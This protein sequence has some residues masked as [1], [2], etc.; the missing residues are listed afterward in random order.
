M[1]ILFLGALLGAFAFPVRSP[2]FYGETFGRAE[3]ADSILY[4]DRWETSSEE[5]DPEEARLFPAEPLQDET[6]RLPET[7]ARNRATFSVARHAGGGRRTLL[8]QEARQNGW[9]HRIEVRDD[10]LTRKRLGANAENAKGGGWRWTLGDLDDPNLPVWPAL[11]PRRTLPRGW[12][13][14]A[15]RGEAAAGLSSPVPQGIAAGAYGPR[16]KAWA[17]RGW[18]PVITGGEP[19]WSDAWNL[20]HAVTGVS[21]S[22]P[23]TLVARV[24]DTRIVRNEADSVAEQTGSVE[25]SSP[26]EDF[27][28]L[29]AVLRS[30]RNEHRQGWALATQ[31][32]HRFGKAVNASLL[33]RQRNT[34]WTSVWDAAV[35]EAD[36]NAV[37]SEVGWRSASGWGAGE[38]RLSGQATIRG[39]DGSLEAWRAWD[40]ATGRRHAGARG[41]AGWRP[42]WGRFAMTGT[43]RRSRAASGSES[44]SGRIEGEVQT[45]S[46]RLPNGAV[47]LYHAWNDAGPTHTGMLW[48]WD[49]ELDPVKFTAGGRV[50]LDAHDRLTA[51]ASAGVRW[52]FARGWKLTASSTSPLLPRWNVAATRWRLQVE[53]TE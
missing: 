43:L 19:S 24:S 29:G 13:H 4:D 17:A 34:D 21:L 16:W 50:D 26:K 49:P 35:T 45:R 5:C 18:N 11:L 39:G 32:E 52:G 12:R 28:L 9:H 51:Q 53:F 37:E 8:R 10:T 38:V 36:A 46:E 23:W 1:R 48:G 7:S 27:H 6:A 3:C 44:Q 33:A 14:A 40:P 30:P 31:W 42:E 15:K 2:A 25:F 20:H 47:T 22:F 41:S